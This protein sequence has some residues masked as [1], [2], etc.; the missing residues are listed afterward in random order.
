MSSK[1]K[2]YLDL[3]L[4]HICKTTNIVEDV[5]CNVMRRVTFLMAI[6]F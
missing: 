5:F 6:Q 1:C 3:R 2:I 4:S